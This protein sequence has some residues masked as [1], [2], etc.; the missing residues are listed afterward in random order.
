M[1]ISWRREPINVPLDMVRAKVL[2][3]KD[4]GAPARDR[5]IC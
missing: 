5:R 1:L 2:R 4:E 3:L